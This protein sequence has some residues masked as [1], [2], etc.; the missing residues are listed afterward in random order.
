M[1]MRKHVTIWDYSYR[2]Q[3][4][5][6][7]IRN[8]TQ[9]GTRKVKSW[10]IKYLRKNFVQLRVIQKIKKISVP[11]VEEDWLLDLGIMADTS[12][13]APGIQHADTQLL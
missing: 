8:Y 4:K 9:D 6:K 10:D 12:K 11:G 7:I 2:K 13:V 3:V 5:Q 1:T